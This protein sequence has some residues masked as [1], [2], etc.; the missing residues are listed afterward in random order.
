MKNNRKQTKVKMMLVHNEESKV[1]LD[2]SLIVYVVTSV[3]AC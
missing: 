2:K 3:V 1:K